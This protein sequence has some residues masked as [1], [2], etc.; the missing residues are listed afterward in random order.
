VRYGGDE[1]A[2]LVP[3]GEG[4]KDVETVIRRA[5][6][7]LRAPVFAGGQHLTV[8]ATIGVAIAPEDAHEPDQFIRRAD[9]ALYRAK[10]DG[11]GSF[12]LFQSVRI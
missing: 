4:N 8:G 7:V 1:F 2:L 5:T 9:I 12:R 11:R 6:D 10:A 3:V